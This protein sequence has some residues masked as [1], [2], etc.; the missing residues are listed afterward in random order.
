MY[1]D[2]NF[3]QLSPFSNN[4]NNK[5][6]T[7]H[8]NRKSEQISNKRIK[9]MPIKKEN[10]IVKINP[11]S[12]IKLKKGQKYEDIIEYPKNLNSLTHFPNCDTILC[13]GMKIN[14]KFVPSITSTCV[15]SVKVIW[16]NIE[17]TLLNFLANEGK[18]KTIVG[19]IAWLF[20]KSILS[21]MRTYCK[22]VLL[23]CNAEE[24]ELLLQYCSLYEWLP[25][26]IEPL[27]IVF[28]HLDTPLK[29][30]TEKTQP[31]IKFIGSPS[32]PSFTN[33]K[34]QKMKSIN[35]NKYLVILEEKYII[36]NKGQKI[37]K[38]M[39]KWM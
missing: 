24:M 13:N 27:S 16:S 14:Y 15:K 17:H 4:N 37:K 11:P 23:V 39:P 34:K 31:A 26:F 6:I 21:A 30:F 28:S 35:H 9:Y 1:F 19:S 33:Q 12:K 29:T 18:N 3:S 7:R 25:K 8:H 36:N 5:N 38:E 20:N 22:R 10:G 2:N 32:L